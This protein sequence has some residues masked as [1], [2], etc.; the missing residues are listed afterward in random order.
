[1]RQKLTGEKNGN[2][3]II[4][5]RDRRVDCNSAPFGCL[6]NIKSVMIAL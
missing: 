5:I 2:G 6:Y 3:M 4:I 1:M